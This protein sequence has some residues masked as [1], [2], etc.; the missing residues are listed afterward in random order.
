MRSRLFL[1]VLFCFSF[2]GIKSSALMEITSAIKGI[3]LKLNGAYLKCSL[4]GERATRISVDAE[5]KKVCV[6][7]ELHPLGEH[8]AEANKIEKRKNPLK[9]K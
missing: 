6:G 3:P 7:C 5:V 1:A 2:A 8:T 4:C 9:N